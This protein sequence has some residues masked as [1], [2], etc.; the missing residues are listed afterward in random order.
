MAPIPFDGHCIPIGRH[1]ATVAELRTF[2]GTLPN[3]S[4]RLSILDD[5][6]QLLNAVRSKVGPVAACWLSGS[7]FTD[8]DTPGD[9]DSLFIIHTKTL[10]ALAPGDEGHRLIGV[11]KSFQVKTVLGLRVDAPVLTWWP[12]PGVQRGANV[13]RLKDYLETRG[14]WDDLWSRERD[15]DL[16]IDSLIRRGYVEVIVDGYAHPAS[17]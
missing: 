2:L 8:K 7:L 14:Y 10:D 9:I 15:R 6:D 11:M 12:R 1:A 13:A 4:L 3:A 16:S 17:P 5:W